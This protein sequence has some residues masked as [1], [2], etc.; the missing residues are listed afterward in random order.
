M[1]WCNS[2]F[3]YNAAHS[4]ICQQIINAENNTAYEFG[5][6]DLQDNLLGG[7]GINAID[8]INARGNLGYWVRKSAVGRGIATKA[9]G[10]L[11]DWTFSN[12][13]LNR[14]ELVIMSGNRASVR[15]AEKLGAILEGLQRQ[16]L[17][18]GVEYIDASMYSVI[19]ADRRHAPACLA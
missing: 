4:W 5:I 1:W 8:E 14:L 15:V 2:A 16:R 11:I 3:D 10:Y 17:Y 9:A 12:T 18:S 7:C 19:R 6:F 13:H